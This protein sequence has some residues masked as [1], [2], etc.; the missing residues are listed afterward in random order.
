MR[1]TP[2]ASTSTGILPTA[3][4]AS[5]VQQH[6]PLL[7]QLPDLGQGLNGPD[8]VVGQH[9]RDQDR[10]VADGRGQLLDANQA[11]PRVGRGNDRQQ[12]DFESPLGQLGQ[13]IEH[14][15]MLGR[16][17][18]DVPARA[19]ACFSATPRMA[20]L[21]LSVAPLVQTISLALAPMAAAIFARASSTASFAAAPKACVVL[22]ALP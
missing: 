9:D 17:A 4:V 5:R 6:A 14:G 1:S 13:R 19:A 22:P 15:R 16:G 21:L 12:R 8:L 7:A 11:G 20:R 3:C 10:V 2:K 18:D